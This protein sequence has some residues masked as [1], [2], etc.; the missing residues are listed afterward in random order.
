[1]VASRSVGCVPGLLVAVVAASAAHATTI[2]VPGDYPTIQAALT[3]AKTG[4]E[5]VVAAGRYL[6]NIYFGGKDVVL[7]AEHAFPG[8]KRKR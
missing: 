6:E 3:A 4:D 1:M 2:H 8:A 5:I 7:R